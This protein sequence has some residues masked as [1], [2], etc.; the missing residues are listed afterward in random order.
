MQ[1]K[2]YVHLKMQDKP[3][4]YASTPGFKGNN[5]VGNDWVIEAIIEQY[6]K[7]SE[8]KTKGLVNIWAG[9]PLHDPFWLRKF[10]RIR[11]AC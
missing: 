8:K 5:Y 4:I 10:K 1:K 7:P 6:L 9:V 3:V 11:K 2:L